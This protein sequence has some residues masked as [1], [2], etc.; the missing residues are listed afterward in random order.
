[1]ERR[2]REAWGELVASWK[3]SGL[4][5]AE[6]GRDRSVNPDTLKYW[7]WRIRRDARRGAPVAKKKTPRATF[8][9][10]SVSPLPMS[11]LE[12][13]VGDVTVRVPPGASM[14]QLRGVLDV[15][16]GAR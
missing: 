10:L 1:V 12:V 16:R 7:G 8:T 9:E 13:V 5:A 4:T 14:D 15:L 2:T 6:F 11:P 3:S